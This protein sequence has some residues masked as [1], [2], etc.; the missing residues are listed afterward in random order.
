MTDLTQ[1]RI[2][3]AE[4]LGYA[5]HIES[6]EVM[7]RRNGHPIKWNPTESGWLGD[8]QLVELIEFMR[9]SYRF[10]E[11]LEALRETNWQFAIMRAVAEVGE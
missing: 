5:T 3:S 10:I 6:G 8:A 11:L 2:K 4:A 9:K 7:I 1:A